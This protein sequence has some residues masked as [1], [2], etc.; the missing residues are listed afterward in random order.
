MA[1]LT[2]I[3]EAIRPLVQTLG[4]IACC[5]AQLTRP[6]GSKY[7][8]NGKGKDYFER[9]NKKTLPMLMDEKL[10]AHD[11]KVGGIKPNLKKGQL[12]VS[13]PNGDRIDQ[14]LVEQ[15]EITNKTEFL[16]EGDPIPGTPHKHR[17]PDPGH[18]GP[19]KIGPHEY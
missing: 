3:A 8:T 18:P 7:M 2:T 11:H 5:Y 14:V 15:A 19:N 13:I 1:E 6:G 17:H 16:N 4:L 9:N 10:E 12:V